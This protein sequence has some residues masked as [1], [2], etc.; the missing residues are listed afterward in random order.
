MLVSKLSSL[1]YDYVVEDGHAYEKF[2]NKVTGYSSVWNAET[3]Y[4]AKYL[5]EGH[6]GKV[7]VAGDPSK[8]KPNLFALHMMARLIPPASVAWTPL[9]K[10]EKNDLVPWTHTTGPSARRYTSPA[11]RY[12]VDLD[13]ARRTE[14]LAALRSFSNDEHQR[15]LS[16]VQP[17]DVREDLSINKDTANSWTTDQKTTAGFNAWDPAHC[18]LANEFA[19]AIVGQDEGLEAF[20]MQWR[21]LAKGFPSKTSFWYNQQRATA[22]S[23]ICDWEASWLGLSDDFCRATGLMVGPKESLKARLRKICSE[24]PYDPLVSGPADDRVMEVIGQFSCDGV[25]YGV[26]CHNEYI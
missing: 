14:G 12:A 7:L 25:D 24:L 5:L 6:T 10:N 11:L 16:H 18:C 1:E 9:D 2:T 19:S 15:P 21:I 20:I 26:Q 17:F 13:A 8:E 23:L 3:G 4:S 22:W